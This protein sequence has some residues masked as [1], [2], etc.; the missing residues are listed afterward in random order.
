MSHKVSCHPEFYSGLSIL[1]CHD[2]SVRLHRAM[3]RHGER[4][5][6]V[7]P[8]AVTLVRKRESSMGT[9]RAHGAQSINQ[10]TNIN[11]PIN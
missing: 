11:Q 2:Y 10:P 9:A 7:R 8:W 3:Q 6:L 4:H 5:D 1:S